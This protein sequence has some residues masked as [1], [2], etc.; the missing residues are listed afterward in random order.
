MHRDIFRYVALLTVVRLLSV[1]ACPAPNPWAKSRS[2]ASRLAYQHLPDV[3]LCRGVLSRPTTRPRDHD[4]AATA[5][6]GATHGLERLPCT[7][8]ATVSRPRLAGAVLYLGV[9]LDR[10]EC[11]SASHSQP[12]RC[13]V[14][15]DRVSHR[16]P[17]PGNVRLFR[18]ADSDRRGRS[19]PDWRG[20]S[21]RDRRGRSDPDRRGRSERPVS[22]ARNLQLPASSD[23][24]SD[25][26]PATQL[27]P[28]RVAAAGEVGAPAYVPETAPGPAWAGAAPGRVGA[29][30]AQERTDTQ[31]AQ[32]G[33]GAGAAQEQAGAAVPQTRRNRPAHR[34][35]RSYER[36][37][38]PRRHRSRWTDAAGPRELKFCALNIQSLKPKSV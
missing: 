1:V 24:S 28:P 35:R 34:G 38:G 31:A 23:R 21:D 22:P 3:H 26:T 6:R 16:R 15:E 10:A 37:R 17:T 19:D 25:V 4:C 32:E 29:E 9:D 20:R 8:V 7:R 27:P 14:M 11:P 36:K 2:G 13:D 18:G 5:H 12:P 33:A 30:A